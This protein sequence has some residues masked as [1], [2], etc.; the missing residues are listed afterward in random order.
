MSNHHTRL[1]SWTYGP[2]YQGTRDLPDPRIAIARHTA[3]YKSSTEYTDYPTPEPDNY[4]R[5]VIAN[6]PIDCTIIE[7]QVFYYDKTHKHWITV[8]YVPEELDVEVDSWIKQCKPKAVWYHAKPPKIK[9]RKNLLWTRDNK[10]SSTLTDNERLY[11]MGYYE[12][13]KVK[14]FSDD[15]EYIDSLLGESRD[16][17]KNFVPEE[18]SDT[19]YC[20]N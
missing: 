7:D 18:H 19:D 20:D 1:I 5:A 14:Y 13:L 12:D 2:E 17:L 6:V 3:W 16:L 11:T 8:M 10:S 15:I 4:N 9:Q